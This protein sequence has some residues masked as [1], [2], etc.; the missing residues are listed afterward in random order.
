MTTHTGDPFCFAQDAIKS[1]SRSHDQRNH[2]YKYRYFSYWYNLMATR[3][4]FTEDNQAQNPKRTRKIQFSAR[5]PRPANFSHA[6]S[7]RA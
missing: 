2:A 3:N 5:R 6:N 1:E 7:Q 4:L